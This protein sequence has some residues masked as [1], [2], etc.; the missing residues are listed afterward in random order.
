MKFLKVSYIIY[1]VSSFLWIQF[2]EPLMVVILISDAWNTT[3]ETLVLDVAYADNRKIHSIRCAK[4][5]K[6]N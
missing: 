3:F 5:S 2:L 1:R 4:S 6:A